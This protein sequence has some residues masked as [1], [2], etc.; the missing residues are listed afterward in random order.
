V[1][2]WRLMQEQNGLAL[3]RRHVVELFSRRVNVVLSDGFCID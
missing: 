2:E 1:R 3:A